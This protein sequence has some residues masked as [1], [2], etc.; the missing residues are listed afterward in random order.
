MTKPN[1]LHHLAL[2]TAD[3][4]GQIAFFS[5]VLG[6]ELRALYWM[7]GAE[8]T[9]HAFLRLNDRCAVA[10]VQ[11]PHNRNIQAVMGVTHPGTAV[12][13]SAPGTLQHLALNVDSVADL[14]SMRDRIRSRGVN[15]LGPID[16]GFCQSI[17]FAGPE[18]LALEISTYTD[19]LAPEAWVDPEVMAFTGV[20][21]EEL[22][23]FTAPA[24]YEGR[25]GA[26]PQPPY[27]PSKPHPHFPKDMYQEMLAMPDAAF[28]EATRDA[29]PPVKIH[30]Q[31]GRGGSRHSPEPD[32]R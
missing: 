28:T 11:T 5:D 29:E 21:P 15:V 7:H 30:P 10:F 8:K 24:P 32:L 26:V 6:L 19:V 17:Y 9:V 4:K 27:D 31:D 18:D 22:A 20:T 23:A 3:I 13:S 14:L 25:G 2:S 12:A 16:H 1:A